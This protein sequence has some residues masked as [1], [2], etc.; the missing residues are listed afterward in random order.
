MTFSQVQLW[1][2]CSACEMLS[3][4]VPV[5][6]ACLTVSGCLLTAGEDWLSCMQYSWSFLTPFLLPPHLLCQ[7]LTLT[8]QAFV[9]QM[10]LVTG[11][12][13]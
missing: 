12:F 4:T 3:L 13:L 2:D 6:Q 5:L 7:T 8:Q 10:L 11:L 1:Q 9:T